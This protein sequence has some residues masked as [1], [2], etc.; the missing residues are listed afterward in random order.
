GF[1]GTALLTEA[2]RTGCIDQY[3]TDVGAS[4]GSYL[5][6]IRRGLHNDC[7]GNYG[8]LIYV[9]RQWAVYENGSVSM[10]Y[11][12]GGLEALHLDAGDRFIFS[13][14]TVCCYG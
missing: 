9:S 6:C 2:V 13:L 14:R 12:D 8:A 10:A 7:G 11:N 4:L 1:S 5:V 3:T